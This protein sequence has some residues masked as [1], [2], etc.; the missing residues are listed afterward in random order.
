MGVIGAAGDAALGLILGGV[1]DR[2]QVRQAG[3]LGKQQLQFDQQK[4]DYQQ[5]LGLEMWEATNYRAQME[6]MKKAG[7]NPARMYGMGGGGGASATMPN[8]S[9]ASQ[10]APQGG[11]E[12]MGMQMIQAQKK[13]MEAQTEKT[14][15]EAKKIAGVDTTEAETRVQSLTQGIQNQ[16]AVERLNKIQANIA[17]IEQDMKGDSYEDVLSG[18]RY[19][20]K[21]AEQELGIVKNEK[22]MSDELLDEKIAIVQ[23]E[24]L[25]LGLSN[26]IKKMGIKQT[27]Q[28]IKASVAQVAQGWKGLDIQAR[29]AITNMMNSETARK[30]ANT[31]VREYIESVRKTDYNYEVQKGMLE[32][33][34]FIHNVTDADKMT[35]EGLGRVLENAVRPVQKILIPE[36]KK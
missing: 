15:A 23:G 8:A 24:L 22:T 27:E 17:E 16:Q 10:G 25:G 18:I 30:N 33:Q 3:K 28:Q 12:V 13:L 2:R 20:A 1:N 11:G 32:L 35:V 29:N 36:K 21:K 26:E 6:E 14:E 9:V 4:M 5:K 31:S 19:A 7:L 34:R